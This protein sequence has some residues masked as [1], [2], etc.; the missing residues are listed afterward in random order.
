[1][2]AQRTVATQ[3]DDVAVTSGSARVGKRGVFTG[4]MMFIGR[5][6]DDERF[7]VFGGR[8]AFE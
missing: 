7:F 3:F 5:G 1:M 2:L 6:I 4:R 8:G